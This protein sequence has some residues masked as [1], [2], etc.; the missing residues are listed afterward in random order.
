[1]GR[2]TNRK[3]LTRFALDAL[4]DPG[5]LPAMPD[6]F[7][8]RQPDGKLS[9]WE[10][11]FGKFQTFLAT[12]IPQ[13]T[14][15]AKGNGK[16]PFFAWSVLPGFTC[17]G[18]GDC[19]VIKTGAKLATGWCYSFKAWRYSAPY[20]RQLQNTILLRTEWGRRLIV[21]A[22][23]K[24][25]AGVDFRLLVDGDISGL[26]EMR[27]YWELLVRR[28]DIRVYGYS[29]SWPVFLEWDRLDRSFPPNYLLN[30]SSGS[31]YGP[32]IETQMR[33][34]LNVDGLPVVRDAF[35][36]LPVSGKMPDYRSPEFQ[37]WAAELR[38]TAKMQGLGKVW[39]CPGKCGACT[40]KGHACGLRSF[41][42]VPV[43]IGVH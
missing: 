20:F 34:L 1:M 5:Q 27:F 42:G 15:F 16:L 2:Y 29:K 43:V 13:W 6:G 24:L 7:R 4:R 21:Q 19:L 30:L 14:I 18:A 25:P 31:K 41:A 35:L 11:D 23:D 22:W 28:P 32:A 17:P 9:T 39:V 38:Q 40:P 33:E 36:A 12:G 8:I 3:T 37:I 26:E 10:R